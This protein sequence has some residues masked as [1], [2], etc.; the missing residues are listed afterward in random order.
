MLLKILEVLFLIVMLYGAII[1]WKFR[2]VYD[3]T[4]IIA[5]LISLS[6]AILRGYS[7][8]N[9]LQY[10][11][12]LFILFFITAYITLL[13]TKKSGIGGGDI[14]IAPAVTLFCGPIGSQIIWLTF[15]ISIIGQFLTEKIQPKLNISIAENDYREQINKD[16]KED[17]INIPLVTYFFIGCLIAFVYFYFI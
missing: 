7:L 6:I 3:K 2:L 14:K 12:W 15:V 11:S 10:S 9:I 13:I 17:L 8:I 16:I 1:D 4:W 5:S